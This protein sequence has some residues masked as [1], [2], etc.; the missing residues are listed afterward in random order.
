MVEKY[1]SIGVKNSYKPE[2][3]YFFQ[4][5]KTRFF[6]KRDFLDWNWNKEDDVWYQGEVNEIG[7]RDGL[8]I[9]LCEEFL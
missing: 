2:Y 4:K 8:G 7:Q 6:S 9:I 3:T 5:R 1:C